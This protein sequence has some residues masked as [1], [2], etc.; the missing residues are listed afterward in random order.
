MKD[1]RGKVQV[2]NRTVNSAYEL[3]KSDYLND[4]ILKD[5]T[6]KLYV[7]NSVEENEYVMVKWDNGNTSYGLMRSGKEYGKWYLF[8]NKNR[9][10]ELSSYSKDGSYLDLVERFN[11]KGETIHF[12]HSDPPF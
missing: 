1:K 7:L 4:R 8:D 9:L 5:V 6:G 2:L 10:R 12:K 3:K 11:A